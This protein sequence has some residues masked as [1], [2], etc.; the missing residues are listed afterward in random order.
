M[1]KNIGSFL[2]TLN[3]EIRRA[4]RRAEVVPEFQEWLATERPDV[5]G[6]SRLGIL[7]EAFNEYNRKN[8]LERLDED[9]IDEFMLPL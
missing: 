3:E 7:S 4:T 8:P 5:Y 9:E 6:V 2:E 1:K